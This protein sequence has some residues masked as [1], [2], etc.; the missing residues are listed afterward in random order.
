MIP[1]EKSEAVIRGL[2]EAFGVKEFEDISRITRGQT[3]SHVFRIIVRG[4]P[5][6]LKIITRAE[7]PTRHYTC[8]REAGE[9]GIAPRVWHTNTEDKI[10]IT[11]YVEAEPLSRSEALRR[12]PALLRRL[13]ALP[14]FARAP[15]NTSCTYLLNKGRAPDEFLQKFQ[16]SNVLP[17]A[18]S[19]EFFARLEEMAAV[20]PFDDA[21]MVSGHNDLFKPDNILF[22]GERVWLVDWEAA[23][24]NDRYA[25]LVVVANQLVTNEAEETDYLRK[26]FGAPPDPYQ[27]ARFHLMQQLSHLFYTMAFLCIGSMGKPVDWSGAVPEFTDWHRRMWPGEID[28]KD[29]AVKTVYGRVH[30]ER[31]L[32]NVGQARYK[33]ALRIVSDGPGA[34]GVPAR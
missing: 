34:R 22:D 23:F 20:Y 12:L 15:F 8:M 2:H 5:Y 26:Y 27:L 31:L 9:A 13:H 10:S 4:S 21:E 7:D 25:D 24:L 33:E 29:A 30:W 17:E 19:K 16:N 18:E 11:D 14:R 6:L 3:N 28:L 32:R 1:Q